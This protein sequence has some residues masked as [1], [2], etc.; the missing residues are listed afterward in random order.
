[1]VVGVLFAAL[2]CPVNPLPA[3][4]GVAA[5]CP[6][7]GPDA[8]PVG[9]VFT[10]SPA[11]T[12]GPGARSVKSGRKRLA[13]CGHDA[14]PLEERRPTILGEEVNAFSC[15]DGGLVLAMQAGDEAA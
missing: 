4:I 15:R 12:R 14:D 6:S 2:S 5:A 7:A 11:G 3:L 8:M 9:G 13:T 1:M 10:G